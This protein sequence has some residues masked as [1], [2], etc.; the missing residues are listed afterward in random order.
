MR[1]SKMRK[2]RNVIKKVGNHC[3]KPMVLKLVPLD[4][5]REK[6]SIPRRK[7][8]PGRNWRGKT[9]LL[10]IVKLVFVDE[11]NVSFY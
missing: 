7:F 8:V 1:S 9:V 5:L 2:G 11:K 3:L 10:M 6:F 4:L